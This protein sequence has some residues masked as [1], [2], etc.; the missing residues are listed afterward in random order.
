MRKTL[1]T[2]AVMGAIAGTASAADVQLYGL[3][4]YGFQ[5]KNVDELQSGSVDQF[6]MKSGMNSGSRFGLKGTETLG[7]GLTAGFVLESGFAADDGR[8]D[9]GGRLFG[10]EAQVYLQ[11]D[12]GTIA[13]GRV[14]Q[15]L[16]TN[17]MWGLMGDFSAFS[18]GWGSLTGGKYTHAGNWGRLDNTVA[19]ASPEMAGLK[20][21]GQ[22]SFQMDAD[23]DHGDY[24]TAQEGKSSTDRYASVAAVYRLGAL[25]VLVEGD[26]T[27]WSM[28]P[29]ATGGWS[30]RGDGYSALAAASYDFGLL[31]LYAS[32][33]WFKRMRTKASDNTTVT[34]LQGDFDCFVKNTTFVDGYAFNL[35]AD[36]PA[37]GGT[38]KGN[39][40]YRYAECIVN[41]TG[42]HD[43]HWA[44]SLGYITDLSKR[45]SFYAAGTYAWS[46]LNSDHASN[47]GGVSPYTKDPSAYE[48]F[49]GMIHRF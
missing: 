23:E 27:D 29:R 33:Q 25:N 28:L 24:G 19:Y 37:L 35:G 4:D 41:P 21:Y 43:D 38:V 40:G 49:A 8:L 7:E 34:G 5:Y 22:Y 45:T 3:V 17:G 48:V 2:L 14:G 46:D 47:Y 9:N 18:G 42:N 10:R 44:V 32:G 1:V 13:F 36:V 30:N 31:K 12:F 26:Y 20:L 39:V 6:Q 11:G 16:S 15:L